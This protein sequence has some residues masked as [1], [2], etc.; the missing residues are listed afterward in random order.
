ATPLTGARLKP[1]APTSAMTRPTA[2]DAADAWRIPAS[3]DR[4]YG[5]TRLA[6]PTPASAENPPIRTP[7]VHCGKALPRPGSGARGRAGGSARLLV[8]RIILRA[9]KPAYTVKISV[10]QKPLTASATFEPIAEPSATPGASSRT[11]S[12][13]NASL[14]YWASTADIAVGTIAARDV[15]TATVGTCAASTFSSGRTK[16]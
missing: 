2:L 5:T 10:I 3:R 1:A 12:T 15:A 11:H 9:K 7:T 6:P 13:R 16:S 8:G 14:R 4:R